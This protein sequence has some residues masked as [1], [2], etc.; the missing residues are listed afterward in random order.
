MEELCKA[1]GIKRAMSIAYHPQTDDQM[2][3]IN[4]EVKVFLRHY[5]NHRQ[6]N[7]TKWLAI[8]EFQYN[9]KEHAATGHSLF[10]VNYGRHPWKGNLTV[11]TE[12]PSLEDLLKKMET[13]REKAKTAIER[14]KKTIKRQYDKRTHQSQGLKT[15][16]QVWLEVRNIQTNQP[17]KKLDQKRYRPFTI[18][19][20]IGQ[21]A[22][23]LEL[24]EG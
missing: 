24:L 8:A 7:W 4:Q 23:R 13:T 15:E 1:L 12:I 10:Y 9:D 19:E 11:E 3:R 2:E 22:Y 5:I 17:E 14:T 6:D 18:K 21:G 16:E 20:E